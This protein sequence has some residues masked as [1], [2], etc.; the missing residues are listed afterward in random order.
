[1]KVL[2]GSWNLRSLSIISYT[3]RWS[4]SSVRVVSFD[5]DKIESKIKS[6][7]ELSYPSKASSNGCK[8]TYTLSKVSV[9]NLITDSLSWSVDEELI[10]YS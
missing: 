5:N 1:M 6:V 2:L 3:L 9:L 4:C 10:C 8:H 7:N